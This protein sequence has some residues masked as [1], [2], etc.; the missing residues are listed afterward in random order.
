MVD[1]LDIGTRQR[2]MDLVDNALSV[3]D[4]KDFL[5]GGENSLQLPAV[6]PQ[7]YTLPECVYSDSPS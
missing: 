4:E 5:H 6:S 2:R 1:Q 7:R 3:C